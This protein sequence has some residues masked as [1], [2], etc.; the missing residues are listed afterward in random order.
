ML[1]VNEVQDV[2]LPR[3]LW[4]TLQHKVLSRK[5]KDRASLFRQQSKEKTFSSTQSV[6]T[7][8]SHGISD[9]SES[10]GAAAGPEGRQVIT[11]RHAKSPARDVD[12]ATIFFIIIISPE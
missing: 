8:Y 10:A 4:V 6:A 12:K 1:S 5:K 3:D 11:K 7:P 2:A 9:R